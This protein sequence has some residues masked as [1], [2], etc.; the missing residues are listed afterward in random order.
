[1]KTKQ[2]ILFACFIWVAFLPLEVNARNTGAV[3][4]TVSM[5]KPETQRFLIELLLQQ[6]AICAGVD[7][8]VSSVAGAP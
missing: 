5:P 6:E 7:P 1:M 3:C 2:L 8:G 4:Y